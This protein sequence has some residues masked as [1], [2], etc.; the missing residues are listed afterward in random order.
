MHHHLRVHG[1]EKEVIL[2]GLPHLA[3]VGQPEE[4]ELVIPRFRPGAEGGEIGDAGGAHVGGGHGRL[5]D[6]AFSVQHSA[7][8]R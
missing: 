2:I 5:L 7:V 1:A 8:S 4:I 6:R 3:D